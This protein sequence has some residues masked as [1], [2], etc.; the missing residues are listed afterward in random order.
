MCLEN[1]E[2]FAPRMIL[3]AS[4]SGKFLSS[5]DARLKT[6]ASCLHLSPQYNL[7]GACFFLGSNSA[8]HTVLEHRSNPSPNSVNGVSITLSLLVRCWDLAQ[9]SQLR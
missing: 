2:R 7:M 6:H 5:F 8:P 1:A 9:L 3:S 4:S